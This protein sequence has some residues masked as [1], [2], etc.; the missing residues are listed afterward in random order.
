MDSLWNFHF[1]M[2]IFFVRYIYFFF[3]E[4]KLFLNHLGRERAHGI[5]L[6]VTLLSGACI[7]GV[8]L[9]CA[10]S[11]WGHCFA[12]AVRGGGIVQ[13]QEERHEK[14]RKH[15]RKMR[16][17]FLFLLTFFFYCFCFSHQTCFQRK[18]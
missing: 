2:I 17:R 11:K 8:A 3:S 14:E 9:L 12:F 13:Q 7:N 10:L 4:K 16:W 6:S 15:T 5:S 1:S 18:A